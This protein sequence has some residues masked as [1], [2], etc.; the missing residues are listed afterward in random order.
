M[1]LTGRMG[2]TVDQRCLAGQGILGDRTFVCVDDDTAQLADEAQADG[3]D[4]AG[5]QIFGTIDGNRW[6]SFPCNPEGWSQARQ[7]GLKIC[8]HPGGLASF[9][10]ERAIGV[11]APGVDARAGRVADLND[12]VLLGI[13]HDLRK[14]ENRPR[15][16]RRDV[17]KCPHRSAHHDG[18]QKEDRPSVVD[19]ADQYVR[20]LGHRS[21][22]EKRKRAGALAPALSCV[23]N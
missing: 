17:G 23:V 9:G 19:L 10:V 2:R 12:R 1:I 22:T 5:I 13:T 20:G 6:Q 11:E 14:D 7:G 18:Y 4:L 21:G 16:V 8:D 3:R 15:F